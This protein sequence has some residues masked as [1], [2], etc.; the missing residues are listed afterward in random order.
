MQ[1]DDGQATLPEKIEIGKS[2]EC[3]IKLKRLIPEASIG[4]DVILDSGDRLG[5]YENAKFYLDSH[6]AEYR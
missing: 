5:F 6:I 1:L 2:F 3:M 4:L